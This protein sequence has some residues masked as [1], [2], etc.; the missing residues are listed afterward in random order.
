MRKNLHLNIIKQDKKNIPNV[1][2]HY[3]E[4][5]ISDQTLKEYLDIPNSSAVTPFG[6]FANKMA[7]EQAR[8]ELRM[9]EKS[10]LINHRV[11]LYICAACGDI[12]CG[13]VTVK[14]RIAETI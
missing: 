5:F 1:T 10:G 13:S 7:E 6:W 4:F 12:G 3:W 2:G 14:M 11:E 8:R 9:Q